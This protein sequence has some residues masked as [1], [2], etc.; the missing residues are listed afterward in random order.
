MRPSPSLL[1]AGVGIALLA[2]C[3]SARK[4]PDEL[5][6]SRAAPL[7]VPPDFQLRPPR[8]G[9]PRPQEVD[10]QGQAI[11]ALFGPGVPA[12]PPSQGESALL[13]Q[14]GATT[15][16]ADIRSTLAD[17]GTRVVDKGALLKQLLDAP[18]GDSDPAI[19]TT[20]VSA[21]PGQ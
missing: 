21:V 3:G 2:S 18:P 13:D 10:S 11:E 9:E 20:T 17:D 14:A 8:P 5:A 12:P 19:A 16:N 4:V 15:A 6:I 7:A 1:L